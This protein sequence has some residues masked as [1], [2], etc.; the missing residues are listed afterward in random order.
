MPCEGNQLEFVTIMIDE[1]HFAVRT[2]KHI[3]MTRLVEKFLFNYAPD[4]WQLT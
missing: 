2:R 4:N 3:N 1:H